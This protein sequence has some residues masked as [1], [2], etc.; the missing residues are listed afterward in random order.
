MT[1]PPFSLQTLINSLPLED[2]QHASQNSGSGSRL[3]GAGWGNKDSQIT[4]ESVEAWE[5][6]LY[7][8][9]SDGHLFHYWIDDQVSSDNNVPSNF[10]ISKQTL[11]KRI[12]ERIMLFPQ[13]T[14]AVILCDS[15]LSFYELPEMTALPA[16]TFPLIKG[17][18]CFC[19]D[20]SKEGKTEQD[21][22]VRICVM[23]KRML[24]IYSLTSDR[25]AEET[26]MQV[27]DGAITACQ[28][29]PYVCVADARQYKMINLSAKRMENLFPYESPVNGDMFKP[30]ITV[31]GEGEFLLTLPANTGQVTIG[32]FIRYTGDPVRGI[33]QWNNFPRAIGVEFPYVVALLRNNVIEVH[34][35][36]EQKQVQSVQLPSK[37]RTISTGPGIKVQVTGL[38]DRLKLES[39][40]LL[41]KDDN[42][43]TSSVDNSKAESRNQSSFLATVPTRL[44]IAGS[45]SV[46]AL[47]ATPFTVKI[48]SMLDA[49]RVEEAIELSKQMITT[50]TPEN[51][52]SE[53]MRHE[54]NYIQQKSGFLYLGLTFFDMACPLF[55]EGRTD[56]RLL[57][58]L[59][60]EMKDI[61][62][63]DDDFTVYSGVKTVVKQLGSIEDIV[64]RNL[65]KNYEPHIKPDVESAQA[66]QRL[67]K[68]LITN[69]R[70]MLQK[71]LTKDREQRV[72]KGKALKP[73]ERNIL[74]AVD[75]ALLRLYASSDKPESEQQLNILLENPNECELELSE[76]V[77][78]DNKKYYPLSLLYK[79]SKEYRKALEIWKRILEKDNSDKDVSNGLQQMANILGML[80]DHDLILEYASW[81]VKQDE[82]IGAKVYI[83]PNLRRP[84][85]IESNL[86]LDQLRSVGNKGLKMYL[87][88]LVLQRKSHEDEHHTELALLYVKEFKNQL[89]SDE[90]K[91]KIEEI[92]NEF[93]RSSKDSKFSKTYLSFLLD[94]PT[95]DLLSHERA[96]LINYL[97]SSVRYNAEVVLNSLLEIQVLKAELAIV[98]GKLNE[99]EKALRI[100]INDL[101]DFRG[102]EVYCF[103][104]GRMIGKSSSKKQSD[105]KL[106]EDNDKNLIATR[107]TLF[108]M[109]LKVYLEIQNGS[110]MVEEIINLL[111]AQA[112]Y[113]DITEVMGLLPE[114]WS[115][116]MLSKFLVRSLRQGYH[117]YREGQ[118]LKGLCR[119]ENTT[120]S[121]ELYQAYQKIGP[122]VIN[123]NVLCSTCKKYISGS[124]FMRQ[125]NGDIV[126]VDCNSEQ[127]DGINNDSGVNSVNGT[128]TVSDPLTNQA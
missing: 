55:E 30:I 76:K 41:N 33:L 3:F 108:L 46:V 34:N 64:S 93:I 44:I 21:G 35:I 94:Q 65:V 8:G 84:L 50:A 24:H 80:D 113:L 59:F 96:K 110:E 66:T 111:N 15:T 91:T 4:I 6:N 38:M 49:S 63:N 2:S 19:H 75:N 68:V 92:T 23:K 85:L 89:Q 119:G 10:R 31:I 32:Q 54:F 27:P 28:Y 117:N 123:Q 122:T 16:A 97:Q 72:V 87:E 61:I 118:V 126:H 127:K 70:E 56:P 103:Y 62:R 107:R 45:E 37:S 26:S 20:I 121:F 47:A 13:I 17:V 120:T 128:A 5:N 98:Y 95:E 114:Y 1:L 104:A 67:G 29:G 22:T 7:L 105:K 51:I 71:F 81:V 112:V 52:H 109:L 18:T 82:I 116:E 79:D 60:G 39:G 86:V 88:Y 99:H 42:D 58:Q 102:A 73:D 14:I 90:V 106:I 125:P 74:R 53:R 48:D 12:V 69:A 25:C 101:K 57:I 124:D 115:V 43:D 100:L 83:Q 36:L 78:L 77:L 9:T 11:G 40:Y